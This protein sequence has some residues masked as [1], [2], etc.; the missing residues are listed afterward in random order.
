MHEGDE[1][2]VKEENTHMGDS[3]QRNAEVAKIQ[4]K[5]LAR[6]SAFT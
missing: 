2:G 3:I 6:D 1:E 5:E 4:E